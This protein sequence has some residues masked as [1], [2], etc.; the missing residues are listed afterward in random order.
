MASV[1]QI[2]NIAL[3][4][5]GQSERIDSLE[6][7]SVA[8]ELCT[9]HYETCRDEVLRD[10]P[11]QFASAR[12]YLAELGNPPSTW[13]YRYQY[14]ID[15]L[16]VRAIAIPGVRQATHSGQRIPFELLHADGALT[17]C[18]DQ[19]QAELLYTAR[20]A[21]TNLFDPLFVSALAWRLGAELA[22]GLTARADNY[23]AAMANY[24]DALSIAESASFNEGQDI[25]PADS[26][27]ITVRY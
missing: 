22:M 13:Q 25:P 7:R 18:T 17:I 23:R 12:V 1:V 3:S 27:F 20:I 10:F 9:L 14:P 2:C 6:E 11:W 5:I 8:A 21:D 24:G 4:R 16:K 15:C 19:E 26:E